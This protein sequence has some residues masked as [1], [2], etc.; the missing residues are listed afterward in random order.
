MVRFTPNQD[1]AESA[2]HSKHIVISPAKM[3]RLCDINYPGAPFIIFL[4]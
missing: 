3:L 2:A 4:K 1:L